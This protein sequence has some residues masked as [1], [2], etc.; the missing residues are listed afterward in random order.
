MRGPE[1]IRAVGH[2]WDCGLNAVI[3]SGLIDPFRRSHIFA[4][5]GGMMVISGEIAI[6]G[7]ACG[8]SWVIRAYPP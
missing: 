1:P 8:S 3:I 4:V 6:K 5:M 7:R 2:A